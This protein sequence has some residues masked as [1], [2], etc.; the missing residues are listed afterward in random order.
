MIRHGDAGLPI[1]QEVIRQIAEVQE[2]VL[3]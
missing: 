3:G 2:L 1:A